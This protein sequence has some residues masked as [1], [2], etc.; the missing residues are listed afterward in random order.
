MK[1]TQLGWFWSVS[2]RGVLLLVPACLLPSSS[3]VDG[4]GEQDVEQRI[5]LYVEQAR[6]K[7]GEACCARLIAVS[8]TANAARLIINKTKKG[9]IDKT[10]CRYQRKRVEIGK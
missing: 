6:P 7:R 8:I 4:H 9:V 2:F 3:F 10:I 1:V 5:R